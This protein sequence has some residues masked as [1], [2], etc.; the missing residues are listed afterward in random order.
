M[1]S[2]RKDESNKPFLS[3]LL[4]VISG[5]AFE[6]IYWAVGDVGLGFLDDCMDYLFD[7]F[8]WEHHYYINFYTWFF[9]IYC[10]GIAITG[11][12]L[13]RNCRIK[14]GKIIN[15]GTITT[16]TFT[17]LMLHVLF[18]EHDSVVYYQLHRKFYPME[19]DF[20]YVFFALLLGSVYLLWF[21]TII[22]TA[23]IIL[24]DME[25]HEKQK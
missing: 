20:G 2:K 5:I 13:I 12:V 22:I 16:A 15:L 7:D 6:T 19:D 14:S 10:V 8:L 18:M 17:A 3:V 25:N 23:F 24:K 21:L 9:L 4:A 1:E 11:I